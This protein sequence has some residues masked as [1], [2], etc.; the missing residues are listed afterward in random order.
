M[1]RL[2]ARL[3]CLMKNVIQ[4]NEISTRYQYMYSLINATSQAVFER[5]NAQ[6]QDDVVV[7]SVV[8]AE[9]FYGA[10]HSQNPAKNLSNQQK[11]LTLFYSLPFDDVAA[12]YYGRIRADLARVGAPIGNNDLMIASIALAHGLILVTHNLKEFQ[13]VPRLRIEDWEAPPMLSDK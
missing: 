4:S 10:M 1:I 13:R 5:L 8:K 3:N 12:E 2:S 11:F 6:K 7:C 9:L